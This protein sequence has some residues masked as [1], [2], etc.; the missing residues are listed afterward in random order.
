MSKIIFKTQKFEFQTSHLF[1][2]GILCLAFVISF[3]IRSE[4]I[5]YGLELNEFDPFFNYRATKF[6]VENGIQNYLSWHDDMSWYPNGRDVSA[7]SQVML[8]ITTAVLYQIFGL[9]NSLYHFTIFFPIIIGSLTVIVIFALV[10]VIAG[11]TASLFSALFFAVAP[12]II[13]RGSAG[14]FKS[15]PLGLFYGFLGLYLFLS[16]IKSQR[17]KPSV[18]KLSASGLFLAFGLASWGGIQFLIIP[19]G[20]FLFTVPFLRHDSKF[21]IW[22]I[23]L[24][25]FSTLL[26]SAIFERPGISFT[27]GLGGIALIIPTVYIVLCIVLFSKQN[28]ATR[29]RNHALLLAGII[30]LGGVFLFL[31]TETRI[32]P[33]PSYRYLNAL[34]PF[35]TTNDALVDSVSEHATNSID[36]SFYFLSFL[37]ILAGI[38]IWSIFKNFSKNQ[39]MIKSNMAIFVLILG[40]VGVYASS[41]FIRLELFS[42][43]SVIVLA[44]I[45]LS[46]LTSEFKQSRKIMNFSFIGIM[47]FFLAMPL[48]VPSVP[49]WSNVVNSPPTILN[50]GTKYAI[51]SSDWLDALDWMKNN[52]P[53]NSV[54]VSWWDYGYWIETLG[55]RKSFIDNATIDSAAIVNIAKIFFSNPDDAWKKLHD[56]NAD[57]VLV[58]VSGQQL[59]TG[60]QMPLYVLDG[61]GEES[62]KPWILKI[63]GE[64]SQEYLYNDLMTPTDNFWNNTLLGNLIPYSPVAYTDFN[65]QSQTYQPGMIAIYAKNIK[66]PES[67]D[68]PFRLVYASKSFDNSSSGAVIAVLIYEINPNYVK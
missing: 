32:I 53:D 52:T 54:I 38:G 63:A 33:L 48:V 6:L 36:Q 28:P 25:T 49:N 60:S 44:S 43:I 37:M 1:I 17:F 13:V 34:N 30:I 68:G 16:A 41:S 40:F 56:M 12:S 62:K 67:S 21:V 45:G 19:L 22:A 66:Y 27:F 46:L 50:G 20:I 42:A 39:N 61:G 9:G 57:Y 65:T 4:P 35:L 23:P 24:F 15:E 47:I 18:L 8:H 7:T 14:W 10:R 3:L 51:A 31:S 5:Q 59:Q 64:S 26:F 2:I 11:T 29:K 58:F 55:E